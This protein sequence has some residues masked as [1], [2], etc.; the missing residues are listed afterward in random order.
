M[1][2]VEPFCLNEAT[3]RLGLIGDLPGPRNYVFRQHRPYVELL[4]W[5]RGLASQAFRGGVGQIVMPRPCNSARIEKI[6]AGV[7]PFGGRALNRKPISFLES[8]IYS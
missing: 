7:E 5:V 6:R 1:D 3:R 2:S 8:D 4:L